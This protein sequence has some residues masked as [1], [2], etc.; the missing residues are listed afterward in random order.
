VGHRQQQ[1]GD[2]VTA[3]DINVA[4]SIGR[5]LVDE[6]GDKIGEVKDIYLDEAT[7]RP[8]WFAVK[9]GLFGTRLSFV[10]TA[11][12]FWDDDRLAVPY[13]KARVKDAPHVEPDGRLSQEEEATLYRHY[14]LGY[15]EQRSDTGLPE[16]GKSRGEATTTGRRSDDA[17]TRSE[18]ELV[19]GKRSQA[20]GT[21]RL[22]KYVETEHR[23]VT[24]PVMRE[25]AKLVTEPITDANRDE[26][27]RGPEI[28]EGVHEETLYE[29]EPVVEKRAVPK[30]RVRL[31][32]EAETE[33]R[34]VGADLRKEQIRTEGEVDERSKRR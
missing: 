12:A 11:G 10:P 18:E 9:T 30:E 17:M 14:G 33:Q 23:T 3:T 16:G 32:K 5:Q 21:V 2:D 24:I 8:E 15:G 34:E 28:S 6:D 7:G 4:E 22:V 13:N 1:E 27:M 29:E 25:R 20:A 19:A 26:A 31:E